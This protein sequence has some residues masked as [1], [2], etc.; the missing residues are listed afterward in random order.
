MNHALHRD[1]TPPFTVLEAKLEVHPESE[2]TRY[3]KKEVCNL[4]EEMIPSAKNMLS[5][6]L[7]LKENKSK[8]SDGI[9][10]SASIVLPLLEWVHR[11]VVRLRWL[12]IPLV[13]LIF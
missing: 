2:L 6:V 8:Y 4:L 1:V 12:L 7:L 3:P 10:S 9:A 5:P 11:R 13:A